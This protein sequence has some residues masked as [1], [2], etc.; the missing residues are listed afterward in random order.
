MVSLT[1]EQRKY[2]ERLQHVVRVLLEVKEDG[3]LFSLRFWGSGDSGAIKELINDNL[4]PEGSC[5]TVACAIGYAGLD[6]WFRRRGFITQLN[7]SYK[8]STF[9]PRYRASG[10]EV[11]EFSAVQYFFDL[12]HDETYELFVHNRYDEGYTIDDVIVRINKY[13]T[14]RYGKE[15]VVTPENVVFLGV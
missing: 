9:S 1:S 15:H 7:S 2:C 14:D 8:D 4:L 11:R 6:P 5:G 13:I 12:A 3:R 10:S